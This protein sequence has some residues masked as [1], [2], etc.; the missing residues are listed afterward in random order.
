MYSKTHT[1]CTV[2]GHIVDVDENEAVPSAP[3]LDLMDHVYKLHSFTERRETS[4]AFTPY[5]GGDIDGCEGGS[6]PLPWAIEAYPATAFEDEVHCLSCHGDG[7]NSASNGYKERCFYCHSSTHGHGRQDCLKCNAKGKVPCPPCDS[8]GQ[9]RCFIQLTITWKVNSSEHIVERMSLPEELVRSV[10][11]QIAF[12]EEAPRVT[13][14][15]HFPDETINMASVQLLQSHAQIQTEQRLL[16][17]VLYIS[18]CLYIYV[19]VNE[20]WVKFAENKS[21]T[22]YLSQ[23][24][25][26]IGKAEMAY[27]MYMGLKTKYTPPIILKGVVVAV[28]YCSVQHLISFGSGYIQ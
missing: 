5:G 22:S 7:W 6:P 17:Q 24:L 1:N 11:G 9:I 10:T 23:K 19:A 25:T 28:R 15:N 20:N 2:A 12:E 21:S 8:Y 18:F 14:I 4:W 27:F 16:A 3:P 13:P 26:S